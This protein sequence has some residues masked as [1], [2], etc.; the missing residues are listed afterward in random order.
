[1]S[2]RFGVNAHVPTCI[3]IAGFVGAKGFL[4]LYYYE[5]EQGAEGRL[6]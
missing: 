2:G 3:R 4:C 5:R 1:M 6:R